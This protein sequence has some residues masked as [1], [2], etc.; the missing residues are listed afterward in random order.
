MCQW[1]LHVNEHR[2]SNE[3]LCIRGRKA[4]AL[5]WCSPRVQGLGWQGVIALAT[6]MG[7]Q[8]GARYPAP[9]A[10]CHV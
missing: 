4:V 3:S 7:S 5:K 6:L 10:A 2:Y 8:V 9:R 1:E